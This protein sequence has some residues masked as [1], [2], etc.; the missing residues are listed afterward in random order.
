[1]EDYLVY[2]AD[3][4][5]PQCLT[6]TVFEE[7]HWVC[8]DCGLVLL[9]P[10]VTPQKYSYKGLRRGK[11]TFVSDF[12]SYPVLVWGIADELPWMPC[13]ARHEQVAN[14]FP[15]DSFQRIT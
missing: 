13:L 6:R 14:R 4:N 12:D 9:S 1:M 5:C 15:A 11:G 2:L 8:A 7:T 3:P 10:I